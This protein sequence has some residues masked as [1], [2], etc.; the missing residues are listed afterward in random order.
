MKKASL[1]LLYVMVLVSLGPFI[2][3]KLWPSANISG[4]ILAVFP[5]LALLGGLVLIG[6]GGLLLW[7]ANYKVHKVFGVFALVMGL[8]TLYEIWYEFSNY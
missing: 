1:A 7:F 3:I 4:D 8:L 5:M 6:S 2:L